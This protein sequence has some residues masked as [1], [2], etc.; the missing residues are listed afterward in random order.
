MKKTKEDYLKIIKNLKSWEHEY[1]CMDNPSVPDSVYDHNMI[2]LKSI[3]EENPDWITPDS[4]TQKIGGVISGDFE[5]VKHEESMLSLG[6]AND[7]EERIKHLE[8]IEKKEIEIQGY[9]AEVKLDGLAISILYENGKLIR[10]A[11]RGN[12]ELGEDVTKNIKTIK[13]VPLEL[14]GNYPERIEIRGEVVMPIKGF[15]KLNKQLNKENKKVYVNPRNAAAGSLRNKD[16]NITAKRPLAFY[17]YSL[18]IYEGLDKPSTHFDCLEKVKE[19]G[20]M[21]PKEV[22]LIENNNGVL[23]YY[24]NIL[25]NRDKLDY[26]IDGVVIKVNSLEAQKEIGFASKY[27]KWAKAYKFPSEEA[28]TK[29]LDVIFQTGRTGAV[30]PVANLEPVHIGGVTVSRATLHNIDE[31]ERLDIKI[32]DTV[33]VKRA[34]D[35]IPK[36]VGVVE[37]ERLG[38]ELTDVVFPKTCPVC[39]SPIE[40]EKTISRCTGNLLCGAQLKESIH[41][42]VSRDA[43]NVDNC[44]DKLVESLVE[45]KMINTVVDLYN[46]TKEELLTLDRMADKS[47]QKVLNSLENSKKTTLNKFIYGLGIREVGESTAKNL[48]KHFS[49]LEN[50]E[51]AEVEELREVEDIGE[52]VAEHIYKYFQNEKNKKLVEDLR[53]LGIE[54]DDFVINLENQPLKGK[55]VVLTGT[56]STMKRSEGKE[57]LELLGAKVSGSVSAS[58]DFVVAGENAG[59]KLAEATKLNK[60]IYDEKGFVELLASFE[61]KNE[62]ENFLDK[63]IEENNENNYK[64]VIKLKR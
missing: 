8:E 35:V 7:E 49:S 52:V 17:A 48:A 43:L 18:G 14:S 9:T 40:R 13:N 16:S 25:E 58:T 34:A 32:G 1:H 11:T 24:N 62:I 54:W 3:E 23:E 37:S 30:T 26:E 5:Q 57:K 55:K 44:G 20:L 12:G 45:K 10:A 6:N 28:P 22:R 59:K 46:I 33:I 27:P 39:N 38:V 42:F 41:H 47:A 60:V 29:I 61:K 63:K 21:V 50:I 53:N 15:E 31:L 64:K 4:P 36:V 51:K 2:V 56:L 19:L